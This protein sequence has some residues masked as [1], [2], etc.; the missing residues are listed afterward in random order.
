[1]TF[2]EAHNWCLK[3]EAEVFFT[4]REAL[5]ESGIPPIGKVQFFVKEGGS[6]GDTLPKAVENWLNYSQDRNA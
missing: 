4:P 2:E 3:N 5:D 1:M 6:A